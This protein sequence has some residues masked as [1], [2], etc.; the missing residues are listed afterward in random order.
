MKQFCTIALLVC[1]A[2]PLHAADKSQKRMLLLFED[3]FENGHGKWEIVDSESWALQEHGKG[4]SLSITR[5]NSEHEPKVRSPRHIALMKYIKAENFELTF[6]VKSTLDT[7]NH[8]DCC[9]F[10]NYQDPTNFYYVHLGANG[11][12]GTA[13]QS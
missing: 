4:K 1:V 10:F 3:D 11:E 9:V 12:C 7:G 5:R 13:K 2:L 6:K 8:R